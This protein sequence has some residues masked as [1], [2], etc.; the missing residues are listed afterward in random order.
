MGPCNLFYHECFLGEL[1]LVTIIVT[2]ILGCSG[3]CEYQCVGPF[4]EDS[5]CCIAHRYDANR[6]GDY[7]ISEFLTAQQQNAGMQ[8]WPAWTCW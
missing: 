3:G 5:A 4:Q 2:P 1:F 6:N 8:C 7:C